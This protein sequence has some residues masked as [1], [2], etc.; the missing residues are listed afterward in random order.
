MN[1][2]PLQ[3]AASVIQLHA[4][5]AMGALVVGTVQLAVRAL[6]GFASNCALHQV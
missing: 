2:A 4:F 3:N 6:S 1:L 5:A